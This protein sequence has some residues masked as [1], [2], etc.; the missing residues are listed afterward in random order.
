MATISLS[1]VLRTRNLP[2]D[3]ELM[4]YEYSRPTHLH[5]SLKR[6]VEIYGAL[7]ALKQL[8]TECDKNW[9][10]YCISWNNQNTPG[11]RSA[12]E[13]DVNPQHMWGYIEFD[14]VGYDKTLAQYYLDI[15]ET[16]IESPKIL[17]KVSNYTKEVWAFGSDRK[18]KKITEL[19]TPEETKKDL[20]SYSDCLRNIVEFW[21]RKE[22]QDA[23]RAQYETEE[24]YEWAMYQEDYED[25]LN[26]L[27]LN[28]E[29][30]HPEID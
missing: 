20:I 16:V 6:E 15:L 13:D 18:Y 7:S 12:G 10:L 9:E 23:V 27:A 1:K 3:V 4:M 24:E 5:A 25:Y 11:F 29:P 22:A 8:R 21:N 2:N 28:P 30:S 19:I 14:F 26:E 17:D